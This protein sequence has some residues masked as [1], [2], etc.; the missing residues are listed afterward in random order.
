[1]HCGAVNPQVAS[2]KCSEIGFLDLVR[3]HHVDGAV[4]ALSVLFIWFHRRTRRRRVVHLLVSD[5]TGVD[6][7]P[8][9][10]VAAEHAVEGV[11]EVTE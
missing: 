2:I 1:M 4:L 9:L 6:Q 3:A 8:T 7:R 5:G 10:G 11:G